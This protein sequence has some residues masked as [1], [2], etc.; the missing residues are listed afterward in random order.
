MYSLLLCGNTVDFYMFVLYP[1]TFL[2]SH[3]RSFSFADSLGFS[4]KTVMSTANRNS[5]IFLFLISISF[6]FICCHIALARAFSTMLNKSVRVDIFC[7]IPHLR[8]KTFSL[9]LK[10]DITVGVLFL[11]KLRMF[12]LIPIFLSFLKN[13]KWVLNS[14]QYFSV[15]IDMIL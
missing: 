1:T 8:E 14:V 12:S 5:L 3:S 10:Y 11:V 13:H 2:N 6:I 9:L 4:V 15:L 7:L